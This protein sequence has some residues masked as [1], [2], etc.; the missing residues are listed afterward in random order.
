MKY[1]TAHSI[2]EQ[3]F[4]KEPFKIHDSI[5][6]ILMDLQN[7]KKLYVLEIEE[8]IP[9]TK[10]ILYNTGFSRNQLFKN[11]YIDSQKKLIRLKRHVPINELLKNKKATSDYFFNYAV[12][13][14]SELQ[15]HLVNRLNS[16]VEFLINNPKD[17]I[18]P[19]LLINFCVKLPNLP[20]K[21]I[22]LAEEY[23]INNYCETEMLIEFANKIENCDVNKIVK[24]IAD[25]DTSPH[26]LG[27]LTSLNKIKNKNLTL[28]YVED[29]IIAKDKKG[30][31]IYELANKYSNICNLKKLSNALDLIDNNGYISYLFATNIKGADKKFFQNSIAKKDRKGT[32]CISLASEDGYDNEFLLDRVIEL[33]IKNRSNGSM[34]IEFAKKA[35]G[36]N[37][38]KILNHLFNYD[39]TGK[40]ILEFAHI[41]NGYNSEKII[42]HISD[43]DEEGKLSF[44]FA[45]TIPNCNASKLI[46]KVN[47]INKPELF[48]NLFTSNITSKNKDIFFKEI[49]KID[50]TGD[51]IRLLSQNSSKKFTES[52]LEILN[53]MLYSKKS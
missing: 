9:L 34:V 33:D 47:K 52:D 17:K 16:I 13:N 10:K 48:C 29:I 18:E 41:T 23:I 38:D 35:S 30:N 45:L 12:F 24:I 40:Y 49:D 4:I 6:S 46:D 51:I 11:Y 27:L 28:D 3:E 53:N 1:I 26:C 44:L 37:L 19:H 20:E 21:S 2:S 31:L 43:I 22:H 42:E 39:K 14:A 25:N 5:E 50:K 7:A 15:T 32:F 36:C 8:D